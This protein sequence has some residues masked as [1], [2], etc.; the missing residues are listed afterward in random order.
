MVLINSTLISYYVDNFVNNTQTFQINDARQ[1][2]IIIP[3]ADELLNAADMADAAI[4]IKKNKDL[5]D[6]GLQ[7]VQE[8]VDIFINKIY[9]L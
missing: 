2:P 4:K 9:H 6:D 7:V 1:L 3:G 5:C 8:K